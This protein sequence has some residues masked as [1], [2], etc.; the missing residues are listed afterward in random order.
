MHYFMNLV[1][2]FEETNEM[3]QFLV[4]NLLMWI[5]WMTSP[6]IFVC[7]KYSRLLQLLYELCMDPLTSSPIM[8][9]LCTKK[10]QFFLKV[11]FLYHSMLELVSL[12]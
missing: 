3:F 2:R 8:D 7:L 9:L 10:Y 4:Y 11:L 5:L 12:Q 1:F 6:Y